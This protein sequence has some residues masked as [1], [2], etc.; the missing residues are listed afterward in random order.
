MTKPMPL[1]WFCENQSGMPPQPFRPP[2]AQR[3]CGSRGEN[4]LGF[5]KKND[6]NTTGSPNHA[7][8]GGRRRRT[9]PAMLVRRTPRSYRT[10]VISAPGCEFYDVYRHNMHDL[11]VDV[12]ELG[13]QCSSAELRGRA[14]LAEFYDV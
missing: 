10:R 4:D 12:V 8:C 1:R 13:Q 2:Y 9:R 6:A 14:L 5:R 7:C 11:A 3:K